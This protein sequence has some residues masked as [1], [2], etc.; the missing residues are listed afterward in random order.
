MKALLGKAALFGALFFAVAAASLL[1]RLAPPKADAVREGASA[2]LSYDAAVTAIV[3]GSGAE[4]PGA[5]RI[6]YGC[7]YGELF[8]LAGAEPPAGYEPSAPV[9]F[10]DAVLAGGEYYIYLVL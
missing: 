1:P 7:T 2:R 10:E 3:Q 9:S 6:A 8:A 5:Y 4:R